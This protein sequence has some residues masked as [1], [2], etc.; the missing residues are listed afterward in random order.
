MISLCLQCYPG[1]LTPTGELV[2]LI[3]ALEPQLR[4]DGEFFLVYRRDCPH[5]IVKAF[6]ERAGRKFARAR[7]CMARNHAVGWAE[8]CNMLAMSAFMEMSLL[9]RE[10]MAQNEAF[11]LF[12][13]DCVPLR[14]DWLDVLT[15]AWEH[16]KALGKEATGHWHQSWNDTSTLHMN[17]NAIFSTDFYDRH[18]NLMG[19]PGL[20]GWDFWHRESYISLSCD[21]PAIYQ[22]YGAGTISPEQLA[23]IEKQGQRPALFHGVKDG[24][25]RAAI[26]QQFCVST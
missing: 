8:G 3:C 13:P 10:G 19:G 7:A 26:R 20:Q 21:T 16:A 6:E 25:A 11:L 1:D 17:G 2:D 23:A 4:P 15:A 9:Q 14:P 12:E 18:P 5:T 24:S 22:W